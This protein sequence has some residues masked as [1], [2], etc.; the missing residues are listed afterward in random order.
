MDSFYI[1][2]YTDEDMYGTIAKALRARGY[3]AVSTP[4][5]GNLG[6]TDAEQFQYAASQQRTIVTFNVSD[7][8]RLHQACLQA[9][10]EHVGIIV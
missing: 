2:L 7:F 6:K 4:E 8:V 10:G 9:S 5:S 1:R 3:D